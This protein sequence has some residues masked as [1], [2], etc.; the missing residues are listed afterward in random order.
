MHAPYTVSTE[1]MYPIPPSSSEAISPDQ[2]STPTPSD[3]VYVKLFVFKRR[4]LG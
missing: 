3:Y 1:S 2:E 4:V